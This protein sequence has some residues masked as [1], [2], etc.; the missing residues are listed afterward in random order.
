VEVV[1]VR[2]KI[3]LNLELF[4]YDSNTEKFTYVLDAEWMAGQGAAFVEGESYTVKVTP[5]KKTSGGVVLLD[6]F[7]FGP[8]QLD[9][10]SCSGSLLYDN[11]AYSCEETT[12]QCSISGSTRLLQA[13]ASDDG[14]IISCEDLE[15]NGKQDSML[16]ELK[17]NPLSPCNYTANVTYGGDFSYC[18]QGSAT[19]LSCNALV[20]AVPTGAPTPPTA[21]PTAVPTGA[22]T[23]KKTAVPTYAPTE[24]Y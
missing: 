12:G 19:P 6:P 9:C 15:W 3:S 20:T 16:L 24:D 13:A 22:P 18:P 14:D 2:E 10:P 1:R 23:I 4:N 21:S 5:R 17:A 7:V 8:T 11:G